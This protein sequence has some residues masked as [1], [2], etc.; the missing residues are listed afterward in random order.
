MCL[1]ETGIG[2]RSLGVNKI[3]ITKDLGL[4]Q[5]KL[6]KEGPSVAVEKGPDGVLWESAKVSFRYSF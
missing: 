1:T 5:V 3:L 2:T 4:Y 6:S